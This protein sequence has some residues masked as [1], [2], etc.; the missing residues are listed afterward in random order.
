MIYIHNLNL[1][2]RQGELSQSHCLWEIK[3]ERICLD[4]R[5]NYNDSHLRVNANESMDL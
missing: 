2:V 1:L 5:N 3:L 4:P